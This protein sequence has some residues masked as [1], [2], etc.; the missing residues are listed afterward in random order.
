MEM[1]L[2]NYQ[3]E[4][5]TSIIPTI[6]E[7]RFKRIEVLGQPRLKKKTT[8]TSSQPVRPGRDGVHLSSQLLRRITVQAGLS[9]NSETV[10]KK[11][12]AK[13]LGIWPKWCSTAQ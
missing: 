7:V 9:I 5:V 12:K 8:E 4:L 13:G 3:L 11:T 6:W 1:I 2:T 10:Q